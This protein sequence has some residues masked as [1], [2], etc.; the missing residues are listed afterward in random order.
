MT[1]AATHAAVL[2]L[3]GVLA[4][5]GIG[6]H[7]AQARVPY[8][9]IRGHDG[10]RW[11]IPQAS[12]LACTIL[13]EWRPYT[14]RAGLMWRTVTA[15]YRLG[16]LSLMPGAVRAQLPADASGQL[17]RRA[18]WHGDADLPVVLV[19]NDS[20]TRKLLVFLRDRSRGQDV[21]VKVALK[22]GAR[23]SICNE[24][25]TLESLDPL[26]RAPR[27]LRADH[28][29]AITVQEYLPGRLGDR[30][31][32]PQYVALLLRMAEGA[33]AIPLGEQGRRLAERLRV[34]V[35]DDARAAPRLDAALALLDRQAVVPAVLVHGDFAPWNIRELPD[36]GCTLID[37]EMAGRGGLALHDLCHFYFM[38]TRVFAPHGRFYGALLAEGAWRS[39]MRGLGLTDSLLKPLAAAYLLEMLTRYREGRETDAARF[40]LRQLDLLLA[41][42]G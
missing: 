22:P 3:D 15:A 16:A 7:P 29:A 31:C 30:R 12:A 28:D 37:W 23:A 34:R 21:L 32:K 1:P 10:P 40:C 39:Y 36:G 13:Q 5:L 41:F 11:L 42:A 35:D 24:A 18:G 9:V 38:Q 20:D 14:L 2:D 17:L 19:G 27:L 6:P 4:A 25:R 26:L 33:A 8:V